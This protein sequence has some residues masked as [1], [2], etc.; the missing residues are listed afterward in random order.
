M[1]RSHAASRWPIHPAAL[2]AAS[3]LLLSGCA[4]QPPGELSGRVTAMPAAHGV[5][6]LEAGEPVLFYRRTAEPGREPWRVHYIEPL[7]SV[8]GVVVTEDAPADH[9]HHRGIFWAWRRILVDGTKVADGWVADRLVLEVDAPRVRSFPDG[10]MAIDVRTTWVVP[11][12]GQPTSI[13]EENSSIRAYPA[14]GGQRRVDIEVRLR[15]LRPGVELAG[16]DDDKGYGGVSMRFANPQLARIVS[17]GRELQATVAAM[18][19]GE[20][21]AFLWS[22]PPPPWPRRIVASCQVDGR[23]WTRWV[24]RQE[25]SMQNCAFPGP[26]PVP[27]PTTGE[28]RLS[29]TLFV[30]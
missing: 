11:M 16:T 6:L 22:T 15:A 14:R 28:L 30:G 27:V 24:L 18:N 26:R 9:V 10:S 4:S 12:D 1:L 3:M 8:A 7:Y 13:V 21:V 5:Q 23:P 20:E 17:G 25:L 29:L 19:T 2:V